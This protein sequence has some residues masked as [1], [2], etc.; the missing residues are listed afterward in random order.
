[1][2]AD[3][4]KKENNLTQQFSDDFIQYNDKKVKEEKKNLALYLSA[5]ITLYIVLIFFAIFFTW[6]TVF[7]S[8]HSYYEVSGASMEPTY[9]D[10]SKDAVYVNQ[11]DPIGVYDVVVI[12]KLA[13]EKAIIKRV[14]AKSGDYVSIAKGEY[15]GHDCFYV[16]KITAEQMLNIDVLTFEN[17]DARLMEDSTNGYSIKGNVDWYNQVTTQYSVWYGSTTEENARYDKKFFDKFVGISEEEKTQKGYEYFTHD[18][19]VYIKVP[20]NAYFCLG[21]NRGVSRDSREYGFFSKT[22]LVGRVEIVIKNHNFVNRIWEVVKFY[23]SEM[24]E[25][26]AR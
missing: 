11:M 19:L 13:D 21:D 15:D 18:G 2:L 26:F 25:F 14:I 23:F 20:E 24:Q 8:T 6:Y 3:L 17:D 4:T 7:V 5:T 9:Y 22:Q 1:M 10:S 12:N 16:Y